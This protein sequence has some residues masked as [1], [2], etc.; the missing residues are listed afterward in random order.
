MVESEPLKTIIKLKHLDFIDKL[1][2]NLNNTV[3]LFEDFKKDKTLIFILLNN[4]NMAFVGFVNEIHQKS[5]VLK[6]LTSKGELSGLVKNYVFDKIRIIEIKTDYLNSL[7]IYY[8][9]TI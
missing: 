6:D 8:T 4:E 9:A 2:Y 7:E 5:L 3:S 1:D